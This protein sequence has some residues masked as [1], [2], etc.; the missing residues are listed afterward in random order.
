MATNCLSS[1][2][3]LFVWPANV[4]GRCQNRGD[5]IPPSLSVIWLYESG[6]DSGYN[7]SHPVEIV[8][9]LKSEMR[10]VVSSWWYSPGIVETSNFNYY[11]FLW[12][13]KNFWLHLDCIW[14]SYP[15]RPLGSLGLFALFFASSHQAIWVV[16]RL[17]ALDDTF[18][19]VTFELGTF[20]LNVL[21]GW[22]HTLPN[23]QHPSNS[24][25]AGHRNDE[26]AQNLD[27]D[28]KN[29]WVVCDGTLRTIAALSGRLRGVHHPHTYWTRSEFPPDQLHFRC[30]GYIS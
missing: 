8:A 15:L 29:L 23:G 6:Q 26:K 9:R 12:V 24:S 28:S 21:S 17:F 7:S 19:F 22:G 4:S 11:D 14:T 5:S 2:V 10:L 3:Q 30:I 27:F 25:A 16:R 13:I 1:V 18:G 20:N